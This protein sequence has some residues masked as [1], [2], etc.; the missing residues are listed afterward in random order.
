MEKKLADKEDQERNTKTNLAEREPK[1]KGI[2]VLPY[3]KGLTVRVE[4]IM[5][6]EIHKCSDETSP[7]F[8]KYLG[9]SQRQM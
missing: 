3:V 4:R 7:N 5:R 6:K 9:P 2:V 1:N 8:K